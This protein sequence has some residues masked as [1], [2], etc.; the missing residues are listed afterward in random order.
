MIDA[1]IDNARWVCSMQT[2]RQVLALMVQQLLLEEYLAHTPDLPS[3][4]LSLEEGVCD[5]NVT[6]QDHAPLP[7]FPGQRLAFCLTCF[8]CDVM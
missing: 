2:G 6:Y 3:Q 8:F 5:L 4:I 7:F 1:R